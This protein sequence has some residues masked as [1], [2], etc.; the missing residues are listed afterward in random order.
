[1]KASSSVDSVGIHICH[2][3]GSDRGIPG[4]ITQLHLPSAGRHQLHAAEILVHRC[5]WLIG[6]VQ[7]IGQ[8]GSVAL[9]AFRQAQ[10]TLRWFSGTGWIK[11]MKYS[12]GYKLVIS[13][14]IKNCVQRL[15]KNVFLRVPQFHFRKLV[16]DLKGA[17]LYHDDQLWMLLVL[18]ATFK[19]TL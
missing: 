11:T 13:V 7:L 14:F 15:D 4:S 2:V 19:R 18:A 5:P 3:V 1:M 12:L 9:L 8:L 16:K 6:L 10:G 17:E